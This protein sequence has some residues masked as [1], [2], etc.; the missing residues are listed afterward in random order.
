MVDRGTSPVAVALG[1]SAWG[2]PVATALGKV[3]GTAVGSRLLES[4][5]VGL[6]TNAVFSFGWWNISGVGQRINLLE[7][8]YNIRSAAPFVISSKKLS[9]TC[10]LC[11]F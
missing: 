1:R 9:T 2:A 8:V 10:L 4:G 3:G 5:K 11:I 6:L 7:G